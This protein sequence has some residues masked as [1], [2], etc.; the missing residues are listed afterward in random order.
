MCCRWFHVYFICCTC[1]WHAVY[2][3]VFAFEG[4]N[5]NYNSKLSTGDPYLYWLHDCYDYNGDTQYACDT[6]FSG[7][8]KYNKDTAIR[9]A[10][11]FP[12]MFTDFK[13]FANQW[14]WIGP[15]WTL[16]YNP[17]SYA[18]LVGGFDGGSQYNCNPNFNSKHMTCRVHAYD[19]RSHN[20]LYDEK[21]N[22]CVPSKTDG[23]CK[24]G[25]YSQE[26]VP[27]TDPS[28]GSGTPYG[29]SKCS[30]CEAGSWLTCRS[31]VSSG[32]NLCSYPVQRKV[33]TGTYV[34]DIWYVKQYLNASALPDPVP[35]PQ[36]PLN[37]HIAY[38]LKWVPEIPGRWAA[39]V[40][41][42]K[43]DINILPQI[44]TLIGECY[45]CKYAVGVSHY[46]ITLNGAASNGKLPFKCIGG[47]NPP[48]QCPD[49]QV[50]VMDAR[51]W[52]SECQCDD[53]YYSDARGGTCQ[54]CPA[55]SYCAID[56]KNS[57]YWTQKLPCPKYYYSLAGA[58]I[59]TKCNTD[60]ASCCPSGVKDCGLVRTACLTDFQDRDSR[61][62]DCTSCRELDPQGEAPCFG[63]YNAVGVGAGN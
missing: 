1:T 29:V 8:Y 24:A 26:P 10:V 42:Q 30:W 39:N 15:E 47:A 6:Y 51:G 53:G 35:P 37:R 41:L 17:L 18:G 16:L 4:S 40:G 46:G 43:S 32:D 13:Y 62:I 57:P 52:A 31:G 48:I 2:G 28:T 9:N 50:A 12:E 55:G 5:G 45:P 61:C 21:C 58:S 36:T 59:C 49:N 19:E 22:V 33:W 23:T 14:H 63:I 11:P 25:Q 7:R 44:G 38:D 54:R 60:S 56:M 34:D 3:D 20:D 27:S